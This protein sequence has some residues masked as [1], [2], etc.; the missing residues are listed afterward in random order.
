MYA[1]GG[2]EMIF[3]V[4]L[5]LGFIALGVWYFNKMIDSGLNQKA[6][7]TRFIALLLAAML[8]LFMV[9]KLVSFGTPLLTEE[10]SNSLFEL[11]KN[12]VLVVFGYQF[13]DNTK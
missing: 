6:W 9:D 11:I 7:L 5:S 4:L 12:I 13:N 8:G 1:V 3:G 2:Y 10:M